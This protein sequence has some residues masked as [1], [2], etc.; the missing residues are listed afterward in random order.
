M[1]CQAVRE[2][3]RAGLEAGGVESELLAAATELDPQELVEAW[4]QMRYRADQ[5][6]G[7]EAEE[8]RHRQRWLHLRQTWSGSFRLEGQLDAEGGVTLKTAL[9]GLIG[10][11]EPDDQRSPAQRRADALVELSGR[12]L[13]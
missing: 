13:D 11:P 6:A 5:E 7:E 4:W 10:K 9:K 2:A 12:C 3:E 1:I 8:E